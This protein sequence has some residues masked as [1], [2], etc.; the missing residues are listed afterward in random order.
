MPKGAST[1]TVAIRPV[2]AGA[3]DAL[4]AFG[5][6]WDLSLVMLMNPT[7]WGDGV[8][9]GSAL[10]IVGAVKPSMARSGHLLGLSQLYPTSLDFWQTS[11]YQ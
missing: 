1:V 8:L 11:T 9:A 7:S 6:T 3:D 4:P 2:A 10:Y 5:F